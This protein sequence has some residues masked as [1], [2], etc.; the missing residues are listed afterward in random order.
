MKLLL[1]LVCVSATCVTPAQVAYSSFEAGDVYSTGLSWGVMGPWYA[2]GFSHAFQF[3]SAV[4]GVVDNIRFAGEH[5]SGDPTVVLMLYRD[6]GGIA[7]GMFGSWS[8]D[9]ARQAP[10]I[11]AV[12]NSNNGIMLTAGE[13]YWLGM[14]VEA[15]GHLGWKF[16][17]AS[18][19]KVRKGVSM[20]NG[21]TYDY[22][23]DMT[24]SAYDISVR[25]VPEP[26]TLVVLSLGT[27]A[28]LTRRRRR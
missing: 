15:D 23:D 14:R 12:H 17:A 26:A 27:L 24:P 6:N 11:D 21:L 8:V 18:I 3:E 13:K 19:P 2:P 25:P 20:D 22:F 9:V 28:A 4:T 5:F 1:T 7:T 16:A 10:G